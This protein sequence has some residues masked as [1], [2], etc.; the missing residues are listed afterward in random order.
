MSREIIPPGMYPLSDP[1]PNSLFTLDTRQ[2]AEALGISPRTVGELARSGKLL[3]KFVSSSG[4]Y[5]CLHSDIASYQREQA[6][7][8]QGRTGA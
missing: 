6:R 2:T 3:F 5:Q 1:P 7:K 4:K 8:Q